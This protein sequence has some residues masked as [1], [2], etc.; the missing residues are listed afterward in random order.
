MM[1]ELALS[2]DTRHIIE[3]ILTA[4]EREVGMERAAVMADTRYRF[5]EKLLAT[6]YTRAREEGATLT[7]RLDRVLTHPLLAIPVFLLMMLLVFYITFGPFGT[8]LADGFAALVQRGRGRAGRGAGG[9]GRG[10]LGAEPPGGRRAH[11]RWQRAFLPA[12]DSAS[13]FAPVHSGGQRL[14]GPRGRFSW[15]SR[16]AGSASMAGP[17][18]R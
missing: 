11:G 3:E 10:R 1:E 13:V 2:E 12:H 15:I 9:L 5:I 4:M 14:Y 16:F 8:W 6:C 18:S 7:D 17:S